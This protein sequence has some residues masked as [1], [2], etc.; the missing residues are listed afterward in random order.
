MPSG[1]RNLPW[2]W[3]SRRA[4]TIY[5]FEL[6]HLDIVLPLGISFY[7]FQTLSYALDVYRQHIKA[8]Q[9]YLTYLCFVT[10]FPQLVA[11]PIVRAGELIHQLVSRPIWNV[12]NFVQGIRLI[13]FGLFL[14]VALAD[15]VAPLVDSGFSHRKITQRVLAA[16]AHH[17]IELDTGL[18]VFAA[19]RCE[20]CKYLRTRL[21][22]DY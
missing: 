17:L 19:T 5:T 15:N 1:G 8:E 18:S 20:A 13:A 4:R 22:R 14:K 2:L 6:P 3:C 11:G 21:A 10:F 16:L 12:D 9:D 7:T